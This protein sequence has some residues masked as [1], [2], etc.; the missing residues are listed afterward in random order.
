MVIKGH[1]NNIN[2]LSHV[3]SSHRH[4]ITIGINFSYVTTINT[5]MPNIQRVN[6]CAVRW[7]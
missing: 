7:C 1:I 5:E 2:S 3:M 6:K 4:A